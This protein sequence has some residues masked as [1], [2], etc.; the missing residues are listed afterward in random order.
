MDSSPV[1]AADAPITDAEFDEIVRTAAWARAMEPSSMPDAE[2]RE[3]LLDIIR[4]AQAFLDRL[5]SRSA[6]DA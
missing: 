1:P 4:L 6:S 2:Y 3:I 5:D